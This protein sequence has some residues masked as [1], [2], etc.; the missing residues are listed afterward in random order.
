MTI[1]DRI[2]DLRSRMHDGPQYPSQGAV[3]FIDLEKRATEKGYLPV[4]ILK[5][6]LGG[7][8]A[9]MFLLYNLMEDGKDA[10]DPEIPFIFGS[11]ALTGFMPSSTRGNITSLS[12]DSRA[13]LDANA[14]DYF[15]TYMKD[16]GYDHLVLFGRSDKWTLIK[17]EGED[18]SFDDA[19]P[20]LGLNNDDTTAAIERDYDCEERK[21]MALARIGVA[22]GNPVLT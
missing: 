7:R 9:N 3:L 6:F 21:D 17:I 13:L 8:G 2:A 11:G 12:P 10:L 14:G 1:R 20:Y 4:D 15:P 16:H 5:N 18:I 22:G 19:T